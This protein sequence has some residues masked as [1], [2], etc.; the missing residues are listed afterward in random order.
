MRATANC[1]F[2][3]IRWTE[4]TDGGVAGPVKITVELGTEGDTAEDFR[5]LLKYMYTGKCVVGTLN[6]MALLRLSNYYEVVLLLA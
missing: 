1:T 5:E 3:L 2:V 4:N 6:V